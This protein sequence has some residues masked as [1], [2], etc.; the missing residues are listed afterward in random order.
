MMLARIK[1]HQP[2]NQLPKER[3]LILHPD[4]FSS[5]WT[6]TETGI[7]YVRTRAGYSHAVLLTPLEV[8]AVIEEAMHAVSGPDK[9]AQ[10]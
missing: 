7:H 2:D 9:A 3:F 8:E 10:A 1:C 5:A 6:S 4:D